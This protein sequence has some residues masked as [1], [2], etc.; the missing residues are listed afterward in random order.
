MFCMKFR[1]SL[2]ESLLVFIVEI[3]CNDFYSK[4]KING[5][6]KL[7]CFYL[8]SSIN[9]L[10]QKY[11]IMAKNSHQL[12]LP[13]QSDEIHK[14]HGHLLQSETVDNFLLRKIQWCFFLNSDLFLIRQGRH[15]NIN[16]K[17]V[18][19]T[20]CQNKKGCTCFY[21]L[22]YRGSNNRKM[23]K[24]TSTTIPVLCFRGPFLFEK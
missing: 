22:S 23:K 10:S 20:K 6:I 7:L 1:A 15:S 3:S 24:T 12:L 9:L 2:I 13:T 21:K 16:I 5:I 8:M 18:L 17:Q 4:L 11:S 19:M 14:L